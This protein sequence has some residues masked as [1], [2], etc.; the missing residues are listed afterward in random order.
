[1]LDRQT[2][3]GSGNE[4]AS[5]RHALVTIHLI[6]EARAAADA[7]AAKAAPSDAPPEAPVA[8]EPRP[9]RLTALV[10]WARTLIARPA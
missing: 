1:M 8:V 7:E 3:Q 2:N 9:R 6:H 5:V 4:E 10:R